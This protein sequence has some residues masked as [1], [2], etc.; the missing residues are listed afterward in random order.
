MREKFMLGSWKHTQNAT[1]FLESLE[2]GEPPGLV[3]VLM[4]P[5]ESRLFGLPSESVWVKSKAQYKNEAYE[6][7]QGLT[8][9]AL[10]EF[11]KL[12]PGLKNKINEEYKTLKVE[13]AQFMHEFFKTS[14]DE[15]LKR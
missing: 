11:Q 7:S 14:P 8:T 1:E 6:I 10:T 9:S 13:A 15:V 12:S 2:T 3:G 4:D 5:S